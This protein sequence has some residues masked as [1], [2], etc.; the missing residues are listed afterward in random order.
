MAEAE[1]LRERARDQSANETHTHTNTVTTVI[2]PI[3]SAFSMVIISPDS[4]IIVTMHK[5]E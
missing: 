2:T 3:V 4:S 1:R 5:E